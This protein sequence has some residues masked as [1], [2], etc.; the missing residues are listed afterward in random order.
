VIR[1]E[2]H[3][4]VFNCFDHPLF[5]DHTAKQGDFRHVSL[6][7]VRSTMKAFS[8]YCLC[9][10]LFSVGL[11][12]QCDSLSQAITDS[13]TFLAPLDAEGNIDSANSV[14]VAWLTPSYAFYYASDSSK[15][16]FEFSEFL[17]NRR[18]L[19]LDFWCRDRVINWDDSLSVPYEE[20]S[21]QQLRDKS[22]TRPFRVIAG[23]T[24][25]FYRVYWWIDKL[26]N[27]VSYNRIFL[28]SSVSFS[29]ELVESSTQNRLLLL[30]TAEFKSSEYLT[31]PCIQSWY[32]A[33]SRV[34]AYIPSIISDSVWVFIKINFYDKGTAPNPFVR[35]DRFD[36][37]QSQTQLSSSNWTAYNDSVSSNMLC[38]DFLSCDVTYAVKNSPTGLEV[39]VPQSS[40]LTQLLIFNVYGTL[41]W[42]HSVPLQATPTFIAL[43]SG[44]YII[45]GEGTQG[46][47]CTK[48]LLIP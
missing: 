10:V 47:S 7:D 2:P 35:I 45:V 8:I 27:D 18:K 48:K 12:C 11:Q 3:E 20:W 34:N 17:V 30:D 44:L 6:P 22:K 5:I 9:F 29:V 41:F 23:D 37:M 46:P 33:L 39:S 38:T 32:P 31:A 28:P 1:G 26:L 13:T 15:I 40:E 25:Q 14:S 19:F 21:A 43:T 16:R 24:I 42:S 36:F 4:N